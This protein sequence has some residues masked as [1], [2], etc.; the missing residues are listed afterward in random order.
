MAPHYKL[1]R[2]VAIGMAAGLLK[3]RLKARPRRKF[4]FGRI[5]QASAQKWFRFDKLHLERLRLALR[6][7]DVVYT[8]ERDR[9]TGLEAICIV[10]RRFVS[11]NRL[12]ESK[13]LMKRSALSFSRIFNHTVM[14]IHREHGHLLRAIIRPWMNGNT[15][16]TFCFQDHST[17]APLETCVGFIDGTMR[18]TFRPSRSQKAAFSVHKRQHGIKFQSVMYPNG[19]IGHL[20]GP[21]EECRHD[22]GILRESGLLTDLR[23]AFNRPDG[24]C[25]SLYGDPA[26]PMSRYLLSP[27]G[28]A[29]VTADQQAWNT[30][31]AGVRQGVE[32][33]FGSSTSLLFWTLKRTCDY[34]PS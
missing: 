30:C 15:L 6:V 29:R 26:Y 32:W 11:P 17:G 34:T 16:T 25:Y 24:S 27:F 19:I 20:F 22:A 4:D 28:G 2:L 13:R 8:P 18:P 21:M 33:G 12:F 23:A 5:S 14:L 31:I 1:K 7:P 10:L 9:A 3:Y